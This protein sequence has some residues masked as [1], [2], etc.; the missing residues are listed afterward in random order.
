MLSSRLS[1]DDRILQRTTRSHKLAST[2]TGITTIQGFGRPLQA[3]DEENPLL[4]KHT[5]QPLCSGKN[6]TQKVISSTERD[7]SAEEC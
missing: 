7:P 2:N 4:E 5:P 6:D 3:A 1:A